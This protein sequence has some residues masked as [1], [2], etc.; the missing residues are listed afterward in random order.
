MNFARVRTNQL[1]QSAISFRNDGQ[2]RAQWRVSCWDVGFG[3][4]KGGVR[5]KKRDAKEL[6]GE[7]KEGEGEKREEEVEKEQNEIEGDIGAGETQE[8]TVTYMARSEEEQ[9]GE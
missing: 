6:E 2:L 9:S 1:S 5:E 3:L 4:L 7:Q 8:V